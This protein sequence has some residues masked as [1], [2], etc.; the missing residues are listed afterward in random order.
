MSCGTFHMF[1]VLSQIQEI[2]EPP[3]GTTEEYI[4]K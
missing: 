1:E 4:Q 3:N 2:S